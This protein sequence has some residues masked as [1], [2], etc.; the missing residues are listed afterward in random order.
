ML[1][2]ESDVKCKNELRVNRHTFNVICEM[3]RDIGGLSG[4]RNMSL[5]EIV[6]MFLYTLA[7][8]KKNRSIGHYFLRSGESVSRQFNLCLRFVLKL[9]EHLLHK[10]TPVLEDC[11]D[12]N[13]KPFKNC[14]GA[15]DGTY[16][17]VR[18]SSQEKGKYWTR[19]NTVAMN[20]LGVCSPN[21]EFIYVLPGWEGSA[22]DVRV[23]RNA[24]SKPN[25]F[26]V[27]RGKS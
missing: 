17:N 19:K 14:L 11:E 2:R 21:M 8:R 7:H 5:Q 9:H 3:L 10:P 23:L 13:W 26:R 25:G 15:L 22:H 27:P 4:T 20:V 12:K 1:V 16:V 24:L 6:A 18:V